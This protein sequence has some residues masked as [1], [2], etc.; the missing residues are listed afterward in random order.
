MVLQYV[1]RAKNLKIIIT[2]PGSQII[3]YQS[4]LACPPTV[5]KIAHNPVVFWRDEDPYDLSRLQN[6]PPF[7]DMTAW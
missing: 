3:V 2:L 4:I 5:F 6:R 7:A 1:S